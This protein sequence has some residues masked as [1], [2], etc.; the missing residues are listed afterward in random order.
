MGLKDCLLSAVDQKEIT[1]TEAQVLADA[2]DE[3]FAQAR[4]SMGDD[5][6]KSK[7]RQDLEKA[8]RA[9]A[10]EKKRR[11]DLTEARRIGVK[12]HLQGYRD[13][14]GKANPYEA[15]IALL[16]HYGFRATSSVRG[17]TEAIITGAH[18]KLDEVMFAFERQGLLGKRANRALQGDVIRELHGEASGDATAKQLARAIDQVFEDLRMRFNA[19]GG[20]IGRLDG[21]GLP[22][23]HDRLKVKD[24]GRD[25]WKARIAP[26]LDPNRMV[27]PVT[28]QRVGAAG[29]D[30]ALDHVYASIVSANRAHLQP[31]MARKGLG[32]IASQRQD[33]R[34]LTFRDATSWMEYNRSFGQGDPVQAI[35]NHVNGM[36]R[37]IAA[38]EMLGPN[39][40]AMVEYIKQGVAHEIGKM[41]AGLPSLASQSKWFKGSQAQLAEHNIE[42]LWQTLRG[43]PTVVSGWASAT[44]TIRNVLTSAQLGATA[45]LAAATDPFVAAASRK[46]AGLPITLEIGNLAKTLRKAD[47]QEIIRSGVMWDEYL[48]VMNDELRFAGPAL[49]SE[50]SK[51]MADRTITWSGLSP[52]TTGRKLVEARF[53]QGH[54]AAMADKT[55]GALDPRFRSMLTGFGVDSATWEIWRKSVD[56]AGFVTPRQIEA[57]GGD[58]AYLDLTQAGALT[59]AQRLKETQALAHRAAAE[60]LAEVTS[61]WSERAV[62][63]GTP[64]AR[65]V[66]TGLVPRGTVFGEVVDYFLQ[67]KSFGL[68]FTALQLEAIGEMGAARGGGKGRRT[69]AAYFAALATALTLGGA[70]YIQIK[71]ALDG[72]QPESMNPAENPA[73]WVKAGFQGGG[74]G[75]FGDFVKAN[76]NRFGQSMTEALLGPGPAFLSDTG[77]LTIGTALSPFGDQTPNPGREVR[78]Y[79]QRYT[80]VLSSHWA[81]RGAYNRLV[82]DNLQWL[83]DPKA[84]K[85]FKDQAARAT[86]AG[87]PYFV[88]PGSLTPAGR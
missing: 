72:K 77:K 12:S 30:A 13:R 53:L 2:F 61:S 49:G 43:R 17:K 69:G 27:N 63:S 68:S 21:F 59:N 4:L 10:I 34:F 25:A 55:F 42:A 5:V 11:A 75:L 87:T 6:A 79:L 14:S 44:A 32:A 74:F 46:L 36:A 38:M 33:E 52:L 83:T 73:F 40:A 18:R 47:R 85:A 19:A 62:P 20:A 1:R 26:L 23:S 37:D 29:L 58:V 64:N 15:G 45:I 57:L 54:V 51:W 66:I 78:R 86:K 56:P 24:A 3:N 16:S 82:L 50:W 31:A 70:T 71:A 81:A 35:F 84:D 8:L 65:S 9:Q 60:K 67:Y 41:E 88:E 48:H 76:E 22:H 7:A 28:G 39:P 80:P